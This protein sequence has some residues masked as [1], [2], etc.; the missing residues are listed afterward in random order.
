VRAATGSRWLNSRLAIALALAILAVAGLMAV[1]FAAGATIHHVSYQQEFCFA[2]WCV[3][4]TSYAPGTVEVQV[5][6]HVRSDA[7]AASQRPDHPQA[8]L[9]QQSGSQTGGPQATLDRLVGPGDSYEATLVFPAP[10]SRACPRLLMSEGA[11]PSLLGLGYAPSPFT[12]RVDWP[13][14]GP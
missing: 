8:W 2:E 14:C 7:K 1:M 5:G 10:S 4:P 12:E 9:V 6:V 11:W 3:A 13:L